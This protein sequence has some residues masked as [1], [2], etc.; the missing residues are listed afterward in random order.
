MLR[1]PK[2]DYDKAVDLAEQL[3][4]LRETPNSLDVLLR[5]LLAQTYFDQSLS[6]IDKTKNNDEIVRREDEL[7]VKCEGSNLSFYTFRLVDRLEKEAIAMALHRPFGALDLT[8]PIKICQAA[9]DE[10]QEETLLCRKWALMLR[11][12]FGR[13]WA[14]LHRE[15]AIALERGQLNRTGKGIA[16]RIKILT[17]DLTLPDNRRFA[18]QELERYKHKLFPPTVAAEI[19]RKLGLKDLSRQRIL[20][21]SEL[22]FDEF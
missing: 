9:F 1:L 18:I 7:R 13:N 15:A 21:G 8:E 12:E 19:S 17:Y 20:N 6:D 3:C 10:L 5:A 2:P 22:V 11:T 14:D 16:A 4:R